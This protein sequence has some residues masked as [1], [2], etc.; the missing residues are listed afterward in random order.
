[1]EEFQSWS[2]VGP[3][4]F[5][6]FTKLLMSFVFF[7]SPL[8]GSVCLSLAC[9]PV[10]SV[11]AMMSSA[12]ESKPFDALIRQ[13]RVKSAWPS[14]PRFR[15]TL[16]DGSGNS[17]P[18]PPFSVSLDLPF[19]VPICRPG[20]STNGHLLLSFSRLYRQPT[21]TLLTSLEVQSRVRTRTLSKATVRASPT[22]CLRC[23]FTPRQ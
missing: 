16:K 4:F 20:V 13:A 3:L 5:P 19:V 21:M 11:A 8:E 6:T 17:Y 12:T 23:T 2:R 7:F 18:I 9:Y 1:V 14:G 10:D 22:G 15:S